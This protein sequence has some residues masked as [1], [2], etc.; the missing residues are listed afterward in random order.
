M[1]EAWIDI[2]FLREGESTPGF[3]AERWGFHCLSLAVKEIATGI[4]QY[5][6]PWVSNDLCI[7]PSFIKHFTIFQD[8]SG[9]ISEIHFITN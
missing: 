4:P 1:W 5:G 8:A 7:I 2:D 3:F 9:T 6:G